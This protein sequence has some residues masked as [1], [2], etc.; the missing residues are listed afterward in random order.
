MG[1]KVDSKDWLA[2][3]AAAQREGKSVRRYALE[4][5]LSLTRSRLRRSIKRL[6]THSATPSNETRQN[7]YSFA[8]PVLA[9][10]S[11]GLALLPM[12]LLPDR[13]RPR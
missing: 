11:G 13:S 1:T 5:G 4:R 2:Q 10:I 8:L 9:P 3:L 12:K 7:D 6:D